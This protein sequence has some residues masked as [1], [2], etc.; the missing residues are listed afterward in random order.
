MVSSKEKK[1]TPSKECTK[2]DCQ[3]IWLSEAGHNTHP[4]KL[5]RWSNCSNKNGNQK[6]TSNKQIRKGVELS[7]GETVEIN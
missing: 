6:S 7:K 1:H 3:V 4:Q 2:K 5:T